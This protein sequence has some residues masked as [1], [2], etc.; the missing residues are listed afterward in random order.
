MHTRHSLLEDIMA[1]ICGAAF[2]AFGIFL[3]KTH[4]ILTGGT[5]GIALIV[6]QAFSIKF[7]IVFF[8]INLPFYHLAW[9]QMGYRFALNTFISI[10]TVSLLTENLDAVIDIRSIDPIFA[11]VFGGLL[12]GMGMLALFRHK[13]SMGGSG[14][15]AFYLQERFNIRAGKFQ[16]IVDCCVLLMSYFIAD[17]SIILIS[18]AGAIMLNLIIAMNHKPG[19]YQIN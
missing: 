2:V 10:T 11:G 5:A 9:S 6:S 1:L 4:G 16:M 3:F 15:L 14:I 7:G 12:I 17:I 13:S 18:I 8:L 19:R